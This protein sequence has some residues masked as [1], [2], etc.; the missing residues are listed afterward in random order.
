MD[1][2]T[3]SPVFQAYIAST[4]VLGMN[5]LVL[6]NNTALTRTFASEV[7]NPED[8]VLNKDAA[9]VFEDGNAKTERYRRAHRNALENIPLFLITGLILTLTSVPFTLAAV[10]FGIFVVARV[11][12][13]ICYLFGIQP[14]RT[15]SFAI[16]ALAQVGILG[17]LGYYT[18]MG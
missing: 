8:V 12:H 10:L 6:A 1:A 13:S 17:A 5:L 2:L 15:A 18:F 16:G 7:V 14:F 11:S 4:L 9:V 3:T